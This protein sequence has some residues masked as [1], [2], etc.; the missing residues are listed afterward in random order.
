M[1]RGAS[2]YWF[3]LRLPD[4]YPIFHSLFPGGAEQLCAEDPKNSNRKRGS[5]LR[6]GLFS[7]IN[8]GLEPRA[9]SSRTGLMQQTRWS[10]RGASCA[11]WCTQG[12]VVGRG[13]YPPWYT[14]GCS[15]GCTGLYPPPPTSGC[16]GLYLPYLRVYMPTMLCSGCTCPPCYAQG[17]PQRC[18]TSGCTSAVLYLRV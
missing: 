11:P 6:R 7:L 14:Q 3:Y 10:R 5:S 18:Y 16:T 8:L 17:V 9:S 1:R 13:V 4:I 15:R 12:V 2:P